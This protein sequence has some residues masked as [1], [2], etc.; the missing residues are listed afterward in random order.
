MTRVGGDMVHG[1]TTVRKEH[2]M[3]LQTKFKIASYIRS[4]DRTQAR[5]AHALTNNGVSTYYI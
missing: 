5:R 4:V 3:M 1:S 2:L